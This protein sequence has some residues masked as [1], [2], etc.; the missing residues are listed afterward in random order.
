MQNL[1]DKN[2]MDPLNAYNS[3]DNQLQYNGAGDPIYLF[4]NSA[5]GRTFIV[6]FEYKY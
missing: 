6:S 4:S 5:R 2:Y 3:L 1:F